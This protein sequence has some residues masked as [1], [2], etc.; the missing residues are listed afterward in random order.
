MKEENEEEKQKNSQLYG[1]HT[2][3]I[4][5]ILS[6]MYIFILAVPLA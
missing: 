3:C 6:P 2:L 5:T 4:A 1:D